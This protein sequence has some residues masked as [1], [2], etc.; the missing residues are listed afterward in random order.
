MVAEER[1]LSDFFIFVGGGG[2]VVF[3]FG[4]IV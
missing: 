3:N 2:E 1:S 4:A